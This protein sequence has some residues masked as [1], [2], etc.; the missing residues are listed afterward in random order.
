[1]GHVKSGKDVRDLE[2]IDFGNITE[3]MARGLIEGEQ[4]AKRLLLDQGVQEAKDYT[5][6]ITF[7]SAQGM[8]HYTFMGLP[9]YLM[10]LP[11]LSNI[12]NYERYTRS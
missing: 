11:P 5:S 8:L 3:A 10:T 4:V 2:M 1:M 7:H 9:S 6:M 12:R